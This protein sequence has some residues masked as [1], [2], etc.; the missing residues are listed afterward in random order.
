MSNGGVIWMNYTVNNSSNMPAYFGKRWQY[1]SI[2]P[3]LFHQ[4]KKKKNKKIILFNFVLG[5]V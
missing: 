2:L 1:A 4:K 5:N 3:P